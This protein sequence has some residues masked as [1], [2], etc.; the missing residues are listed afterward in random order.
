MK[1][2]HLEVENYGLFSGQSFEFESDF[3]LVFGPN[4]AGKSTLLQ[5]IREQLLGFRVQNPYA[6]DSHA[7]EMA[8]TAELE[9]Q[10]GDRLRFRRRK[11]KKD[12]VVGELSSSGKKID[13]TGLV[14]LLGGMTPERYEHL[15]G[16]SLAELTAGQES[17]NEANIGEALYG[18]AVGGLAN[19]QNIRS[20]L[21]DEAESIFAPRGRTKIIDGILRQVKEQAKEL[22][23]Q[24]VKP[25]DYE[26][27]ARECEAANAEVERLRKRVDELR[28]E[29]ARAARVASALDPWRRSQQAAN[30]LVKLSVPPDFQLDGA[31]QLLRLKTRRAELADDLQRI[32]TDLQADAHDLQE[33]KLAPELLAREAE[34]RQ[35]QQQ[36]KQIESCRSDSQSLELASTAIKLSV[37]AKL[38]ELHP[39]WDQ[40]QLEQFESTIVQRETI[41][42]LEREREKLDRDRIALA[43]D[44]RAIEANIASLQQQLAESDT[45]ELSDDLIGLIDQS[46]T[47]QRNRERLSELREQAAEL[48]EH[49]D[50]AIAK[51]NAP[52]ASSLG[53]RDASF[54]RNPE[55]CVSM[56]AEESHASGLRLN[57]AT[58]P[59]PLEATVVEFRE[60]WQRAEEEEREAQGQMGRTE[61]ELGEKRTQLDKLESR[62]SVPDREQLLAQRKR[63]DAGWQIIS[64]QFVDGDIADSETLQ[65]WLGDSLPDDSKCLPAALATSYEQSVDST[66]QLADERQEQYEQAAKRDQFID[67]I[68]R[69]QRRLVSESQLLDHRQRQLAEERANWKS[70]WAACPFEPLSPDAMLDWLRDYDALTDANT[71]R[72]ILQHKIAQA[73]A[74]VS[75]FESQLGKAFP[76]NES[77][78]SILLSKAKQLVDA[79]REAAVRRQTYEEQLPQKQQALRAADD[80]LAKLDVQDVAWQANWQALLDEFAFPHQWDVHI[81]ATILAGLAEARSEADK[82]N[83]LDQRIK[84]MRREVATFES[85]ARRLCE[86]IATDVSDFLAEHAIGELFDRLE[87]AKQAERDYE[88]LTQSTAKL[89]KRLASVRDKL[90]E[91]EREIAR[92]MALAG[93]DS[94]RDFQQIA[95]TAQRVSELS[96]VRD[97]DA[98]EVKAIRANEDV[99]S[100]AQSLQEADPDAIATQQRTLATELKLAEEEVNAAL[101]SQTLLENRRQEMDAGSHAAELAQDLESTRGQLATAVDRWAPLVLAQAL[102][103]R[104]IDKFEREHQPAVMADVGRLLLQ[105][106]LGRYIAIERKL[107][108]QGTLLVVD[109]SGNRKAPSQLS[110]GTREQLYLAIRLA[111]IQHY[112]QDAESLPIVM[113]DVLVNFDSERAKQTL[114]VLAEV[115]SGVQIIFLTCH[116]HMVQATRAAMPDCE[117]LILPGGG[118]SDA[119]IATRLAQTVAAK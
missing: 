109:E 53:G 55:A 15:F 100:F 92:L 111:Y 85:Q 82:A 23:S 35:L 74:A 117:P 61:R 43:S 93:A 94:E 18:G 105:M 104:A 90:E 81:A 108:E 19:C 13:A 115:A 40:S 73:E 103:K 113:D 58:L 42:R 29:E 107:D 78:T 65:T 76:D 49:I 102:M 2:R 67:E 5:L 66:D 110:T 119:V 47:Y 72:R 80:A 46:P 59:V 9:L 71:R 14:S 38:R 86:Q 7:G 75:E 17:L 36:I 89:E 24:T 96:R 68:D 56:G 4:E 84:D 64:K 50:A 70:L 44:R 118:L 39:K 91:T 87:F 51:L 79:S 69:L 62:S 28:L 34:I 98:R 33:L 25:R 60:R 88:R 77:N 106:T 3:T 31:A 1:L 8:A 112:F 6:F 63:R 22:R 45:T 16:F 21:R 114:K 99:D 37:A 27:L 116:E 97:Q 41:E 10:A 83:A 20:E 95:E 26:Q 52:F 57:E 12:V 54:N 32:E 48:D 30:E 11:G 101:K